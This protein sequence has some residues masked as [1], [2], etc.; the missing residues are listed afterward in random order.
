MKFDFGPVLKVK[1]ESRRRLAAMPIAEKLRILDEL[2]A[3]SVALHVAGADLRSA[4]E[5]A[6]RPDDVAHRRLP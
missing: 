5:R 6:S 3:A 4:G 2:R 1:E